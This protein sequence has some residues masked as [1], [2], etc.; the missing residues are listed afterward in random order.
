MNLSNKRM[1]TFENLKIIG[2]IIFHLSDMFIFQLLKILLVDK[3]DLDYA[4]LNL[5]NNNKI[6]DKKV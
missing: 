5:K 6:P 3:N 4:Y 2:Q 1:T